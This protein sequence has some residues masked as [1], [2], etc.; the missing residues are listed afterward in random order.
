M[1]RSVLLFNKLFGSVTP[2]PVGQQV[3]AGFDPL[4]L[5]PDAGRMNI[6]AV[7]LKEYIGLFF[8]KITL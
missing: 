7:A 5:L 1:R 4:G 6:V 8:Y 3:Q 2:F